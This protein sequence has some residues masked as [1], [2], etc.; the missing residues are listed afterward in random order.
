MAN[1]TQSKGKG[2]IYNTSSPTLLFEY[3][4]ITFTRQ[5]YDKWL[6]ERKLRE[7]DKEIDQ[8]TNTQIAIKTAQEKKS[9]EEFIRA[10]Q[11]IREGID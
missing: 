10:F 7:L 8:L 4:K 11:H 3:S 9:S 2:K 1:Q 6:K 5:E